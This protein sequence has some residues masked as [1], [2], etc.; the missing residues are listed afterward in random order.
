M[1]E[2]ITKHYNILG[3]QLPIELKFYVLKSEK[4]VVARYTNLDFTVS[5]TTGEM[6]DNRIKSGFESIFKCNMKRYNINNF[7]E[8]LEYRQSGLLNSID[9]NQY[10]L[11]KKNESSIVL[12]QN[13]DKEDEGFMI[14]TITCNN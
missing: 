13:P 2:L 7:N 8:Y 6:M 9:I 4:L 10:K 14:G 12:I 5:T 3:I 1:V 11:I